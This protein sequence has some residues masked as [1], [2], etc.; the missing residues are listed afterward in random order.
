M[1]W[2]TD[3]IRRWRNRHDPA[4]APTGLKFRT[5]LT[6][7]Q[8]KAVAMFRRSQK[9]SASGRLYV[10]ARKPKVQS[11]NVTPFRKKAGA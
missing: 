6:Y 2:L 8:D 7:E 9:R 4:W 1:T 3:L 11:D 5:P 10:V